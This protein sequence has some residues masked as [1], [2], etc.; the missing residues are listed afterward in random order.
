MEKTLSL[1]PSIPRRAMIAASLGAVFEWYDFFLYGSLAI[2]LGRLFFP[3]DDPLASL[4]TTLAV[5]GAGFVVR[6]LGGAVF[7]YIGDKI[8]RKVAFLATIITM[9]LST[10]LIG[11]IPTYEDIGIFAPIILNET[12]MQ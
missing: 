9:G 2:F 7:G 10:A 6:P 12:V 3:S 5:F 1:S 8:G 11:V 4:L